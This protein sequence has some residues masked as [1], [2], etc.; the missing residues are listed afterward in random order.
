M[1]LLSL[2]TD[3]DTAVW[4]DDRAVTKFT[5]AGANPIVGVN[6]VVAALHSAGKI[7]SSA[8]FKFLMRQ[9]GANVRYIPLTAQELVSHLEAA[10]IS[11]GVLGETPT[12]AT[13]RRYMAAA[14]LSSEHM[15]RPPLPTNAPNPHGETAFLISYYREIAN[16]F[17]EI[18][19]RA[20]D[21]D[22]AAT[23][24]EWVLSNLYIDHS[25]LRTVG[26]L[27]TTHDQTA[28]MLAVSLAGLVSQSLSVRNDE[29]R[30]K[31]Y[32]SWVNDRVLSPR[33]RATA[34]LRAGVANRLTDLW[35]ETLRRGLAEKRDAAALKH[36]YQRL[37]DDLPEELR[38]EIMADSD[39]LGE[40][41]IQV[42]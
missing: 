6:D 39:F 30:R 24:C 35:A 29:R 25:A 7:E 22:T 34:L 12:L 2:P 16:A 37:F 4:I 8:Y 3:P 36:V 33:F 20:A 11:D 13:L 23:R 15:D 32:L 9:R 14:L 5:L 28:Y 41:G 18:W 21:V 31:D 26:L 1:S 42:L 38:D 19:N 17:V 27:Q 40:I 10:P